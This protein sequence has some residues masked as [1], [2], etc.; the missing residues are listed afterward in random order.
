MA[1]LEKV[2]YQSMSRDRDTDGQPSI[3]KERADSGPITSLPQIFY[4]DGSPF[5]AANAY[6]RD[7]REQGKQPETVLSAMHHLM[8]YASWLEVRGLDWTHFPLKK[9]ERCLYRYRGYL[10][11]QRD[12]GGISPST[13]SARM[14]AI[15]R[16]YRW[17]M[18]HNW[19]ERKPYWQDRNVSLNF[20]TPVGLS[21]TFSV[22]SSD[23]AIPNRKRTGSSLEDGLL[24]LSI[25]SRRKLLAFLKSND[26]TELFLMFLLGF[27]TGARI[28]TIRTLRL[29]SLE[30]FLEDPHTPSL[31]RLPVG[32]PT[33]IKTKYSV[34]GSLLIAQVVVDE[35]KEYAKSARRLWR[36]SKAKDSEK[37]LLFLTS[38]GR[39]YE[40][41]SFNSLMT[42][43]RRK[44]LEAGYNEFSDLKFHQTR[45]TF[46]T[47][48]MRACLASG[49]NAEDAIEFVKDAMLHKDTSTTWKYIKFIKSEEVK[50]KLSDEFF[51][52]FSGQAEDYERLVE[53]V[54]N[55]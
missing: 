51:A 2:T 15:V 24:P 1:M 26:M 12:E 23:L 37:T 52:F 22:S 54:S 46:G 42:K 10:I 13:A 19:I 18:V 30:T 50:E 14:S 25:N 7:R 27:F 16:F 35:L 4:S 39:K 44:L 53:E 8:A 43:L 20:T 28:E 3:W 11:E 34:S 32:P 40:S 5:L 38:T 36:Q 45:A 47:Q 17:A 48:L 49:E 31:K 55:G 41:N 29:Q 6:A 21:R 9:R 33:P